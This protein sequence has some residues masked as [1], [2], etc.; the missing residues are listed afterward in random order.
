MSNIPN[1]HEPSVLDYVKSKLTPWKKSAIQIPPS[2]ETHKPES[3]APEAAADVAVVAA[4]AA[5][6]Q[7]ISQGET[8]GQMVIPWRLLLA[9]GLALVG[10]FLLQPRPNRGWTLGVFFYLLA[11][12]WL[13]FVNLRGEWTAEPLKEK[14]NR[15]DP[16]TLRLMAVLVGFPL[17]LVAFFLFSDNKFTEL[18]VMVWAVSLTA[19]VRAFWLDSQKASSR[20]SWPKKLWD[21]IR[22]PQDNITISKKVLLRT[23]LWVALWGVILAVVLFFRAYR[24]SQVP[25]E[26]NSDHAEKLLD[27]WDVL[28]GQTR[29]FFPRNTGREAIQFYLTSAVILIFNTGVSFLSLKI[30]TFIVGL[31]TLPFVYLLGKEV[32]NK[33]VGMLALILTGIAYWPNT[34]TRVALR[35]SLYPLFVA[36][37]LFFMLR[38]LRT[39]NRNDFI[40]AGLALGFGLHGYLPFR[41]VPL[42]VVVAFGLFLLHRSSKGIRQQTLLGLIVLALISMIVFIPLLRYSQQYPEAF[43]YRAFSRLFTLERPLP[44][45][46][47]VIFLQNL[48]RAVTMF[49]WDAGNI[50]PIGLTNHPALDIISAAFFFLGIVILLVRYLRKHNWIDLFLILSIPLLMLPSIL[51]LA[52]PDENPALNR[53]AGVLVP[54]F[55]IAAISLEGFLSGL[56]R[57]YRQGA[58]PLKPPR[59]SQFFGWGVVILLLAGSAWLNYDLVFRQYYDQYAASSWNTSEMGQVIHF[60]ADTAGSLDSAWV[61]AYPYWVDTRLVGMQAGNPTRD[62]AIQPDQLSSTQTTPGAKLFLVNLQ[63]Q[64]DLTVLRSLYPQGALKQYNSQYSPNKNFWMFFVPTAENGTP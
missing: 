12:A 50:W 48:W 25:P 4:V 60:F 57:S 49:F 46:V 56:I 40:L 21:W 35:F 1:D 3:R 54:V 39:S 18:N 9:L 14:E 44:A 28:Q 16:M 17:A 13:V 64:P 24:L 45:P 8:G 47:A 51:S 63:D 42:V 15:T 32:G 5:S 10:Q 41:I 61:V 33:R 37:T 43:S 52:Y 34:I 19:F 53:T 58:D 11:A 7:V 29:I 36:P 6:A 62:Y 20:P 31:A 59:S 27:V 55:V 38:G 22:N 23:A 26:M 2:E 30:G